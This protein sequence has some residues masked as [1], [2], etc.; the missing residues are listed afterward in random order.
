MTECNIRVHAT[1]VALPDAGGG[2][3]GL[4][5]RGSSGAGKSDL[6]LRLIDGGARLV[7]DDQTELRSVDGVVMANAP[8]SLAGKIEVRGVGIV[9]LPYLDT[10]PVMLVCDLVAPELVA[11]HPEPR[12]TCLAGVELQL[13]AVAPFEVS[14]PAKL[15]LGV[16]A[17]RHGIVG[18]RN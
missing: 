4:L 16:V 9:D 17:V 13:L 2:W 8:R 12:F 7:A 6:A 5:L 11:R 18:A 1:C 15:R 14:T 10:V 3:A